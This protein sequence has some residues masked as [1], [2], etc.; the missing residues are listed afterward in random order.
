MT[1]QERRT[2]ADNFY[3]EDRSFFP[4]KK[5]QQFELRIQYVAKHFL[6]GN[7]WGC[8]KTIFLKIYMNL[9]PV[10]ATRGPICYILGER[11]TGM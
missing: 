2:L 1:G 11:G 8:K 5:L 6:F 3:V 10:V 4:T 9:Q 7:I